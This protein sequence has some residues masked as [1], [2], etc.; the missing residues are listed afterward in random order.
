MQIKNSQVHQFVTLPSTT[1]SSNV[2]TQHFNL[3]CWFVLCL[4]AVVESARLQ[5]DLQKVEQ[6][7]SKINAE[8]ETLKEKI[9][10]ME[11]D[12]EVYSDLKKLRAESD[13]RKQVRQPLIDW[14]MRCV[15]SLREGMG[16]TR[17]GWGETDS[18]NLRFTPSIIVNALF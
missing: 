12:L 14:I 18:E 2:N 17:I 15:L 11:A 6:L 7:E 1:T 10:T 4:Y 13:T 3:R 16:K 8:L 9:G 5:M